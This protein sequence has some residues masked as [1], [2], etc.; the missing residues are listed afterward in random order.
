MKK[1]YD[2]AILGSG[3]GGYV[4]AI[5]A[6]QL[7]MSV[8]LIEKDTLGGECLNF[9]C[10]PTKTLLKSAHVFQ[11]AKNSRDLGIKANDVDIDFA[12]CQER[13][14]SVVEHLK[15]GVEFLLNK[16]GV[17]VIYGYG[18]I[19]SKG[20]IEVGDRQIYFENC[21]IAV[22]SEPAELPAVGFNEEQG[23]VS[24]RQILELNVI[25]KKLV[26]IGGGLI[27]CE[28]ADIFRCIGAEVTIVE[29]TEQLIPGEDA[30]IVRYLSSDF[31]KSGVKIFTQT[32]L[33]K[34]DKQTD[35]TCKLTLNSGKVIFADKVLLSVGRKPNIEGCGIDN[36]GVQRKQGRIVV[37]EHMQTNIDKIYA[38]GD[39]VGRTYLAH[40]ASHE[41]IVAVEYISGKDSKM[42]YDCIPR[43]IYTNPEIASVGL[44]EQQAK[45]KGLSVKVGRFPLRASARAIIE[46]HVQGLVKIIADEK[47]NRILGGTI[48][49]AYATEIIHEISQAVK[50]GLSSRE[51]VQFIHAHPTISES[52]MEAVF[53]VDGKA[54]HI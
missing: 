17:Q 31:K 19:V 46:K 18:R 11:L 44:T 23:I 43:C 9:G 53:A 54:V 15:K 38:I 5:K 34:I 49:G 33:I 13:K 41:G 7:G 40:T 37:D 20:V 52:I 48:C 10:I 47:S 14:K 32:Q 16:N 25:P 3:P 51:L 39:V 27:G 2:L 28:F 6:A 45:D 24:N 36:L 29:L 12:V 1:K 50:C 21:I 4:A 30:E 35:G 22:G 42:S 8:C 26:I